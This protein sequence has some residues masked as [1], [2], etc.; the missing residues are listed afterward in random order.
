MANQKPSASARRSA[1]RLAAVQA[2]YQR[3]M[4]A[5]GTE[6]VLGEFT[7]FRF[8]AE[9]NGV[10]LVDP[11]RALFAAIVRGVE[12]RRGEVDTIAKGAL[13]P[14]WAFDRLEI[15]LRTILRAG[16]WEMLENRAAETRIVIAEYLHLT[17]A[18]FAGR[19][20]AMVNAVLDRVGHTVRDENALSEPAEAES[21][22]NG[23]QPA[24]EPATIRGSLETRD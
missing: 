13:G 2:L 17:D 11:D 3:E 18:F 1:A 4:T 5:I 9:P 19:E 16:I 23:D 15:L 24:T 20:P 8:G 10:Q 14:Q 7:R 22:V 21:P 6:Q 12:R